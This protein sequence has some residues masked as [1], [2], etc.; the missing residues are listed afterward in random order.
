MS[1]RKVYR[2]RTFKKKRHAKKAVKILLILLG[3]AFLV[4]VAVSVVRPILKYM[5]SPNTESSEVWTPHVNE[6]KPEEQKTE[7]TGDVVKDEEPEQTDNGY[8]AY[9][10]PA[11]AL[12]DETHLKNYLEQLR[13]A[14]YS[15][16]A[17]ILK[18]DGGA[19]NYL[20]DSPFAAYAEGAVMGKLRAEDIA[21][22]ITEAG[23]TPVARL[24]LLNDN[25]KYGGYRLGSYKTTGGETWLDNS[26]QNGGKPWLS[27]F[28]ADT[29][30]Y[31]K[32]LVNEASL[33]GFKTIIC[34]GI[35]FPPFKNSDIGY[36]G[37][38]IS[39]PER[40]KALISIADIAKTAA[41]ANGSEL[42][43]QISA[44]EILTDSSEIFKPEELG[45]MK[46]MV[47]YD[48][49]NIS[50][51]IVYDGQEVVFTD[52]TAAEKASAVFGII[53]GKSGAKIKVVPCIN[54]TNLNQTDFNEVLTTVISLGYESYVVE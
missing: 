35:E 40:Y 53:S 21:R 28:E 8:S 1:G 44:N 19:I 17:V 46:I 33:G 42:V 7:D 14:G 47:E 26:P 45:N 43:L 11:E 54:H 50:N 9:L 36:I 29:Q 37:S 20:T 12:E 48:P 49:E 31:V 52:M 39:S 34:S 51:S 32:Y 23:M 27:P 30:D 25:N 16:A 6:D 15:S 3:A 4:F 2:T 38:S 10:L 5:R 13:T 41:E 18:S 22:I 24:S